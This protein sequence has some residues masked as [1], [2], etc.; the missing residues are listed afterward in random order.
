MRSLTKY[1]KYF[2]LWYL[3]KKQEMSQN[4]YIYNPL[5]RLQFYTCGRSNVILIQNEFKKKTILFIFAPKSCNLITIFE[6][7]NFNLMV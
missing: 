6:I 4:N 3:K 1:R 5:G 7:T 2:I